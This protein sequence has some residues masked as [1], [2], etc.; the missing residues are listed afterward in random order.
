MLFEYAGVRMTSKCNVP[1]GV[2]NGGGELITGV[3]TSPRVAGFGFPTSW[4]VLTAGYE[5]SVT[6][7]VSTEALISMI[8]S[9][10]RKM[11]E[12]DGRR[13]TSRLRRAPLAGRPFEA[14]VGLWLAP[15]FQ[16]I[17]E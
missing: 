11:N 3:D 15:P 7:T 13:P 8:Y 14:L 5:P 6:T 12:P 9:R 1:G 4:L 10:S 16:P 2:G 17:H